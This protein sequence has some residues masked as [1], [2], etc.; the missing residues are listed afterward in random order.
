MG[1]RVP[2]GLA[3][4]WSWFTA[5]YRNPGPPPGAPLVRAPLGNAIAPQDVPPPNSGP[6]L[7][8]VVEAVPEEGWR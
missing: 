5:A 2:A 7:N 1:K 8:C 6:T 3:P 4:K